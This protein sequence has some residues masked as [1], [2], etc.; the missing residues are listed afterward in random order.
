MGQNEETRLS[1]AHQAT[2]NA[3]CYLRLTVAV[4]ERVEHVIR[5]ANVKSGKV[6]GDIAVRFASPGQVLGLELS[7][8]DSNEV[9]RDGIS[10]AVEKGACPLW[11][12]AP[13]PNA[14][15]SIL[16]HLALSE[17][18][19][20]IDGFLDV[21]CSPASIQPCDWMGICV[22]DGLGDWAEL[23]LDRAAAA[24]NGQLDCYFDPA[25]G[26]RENVRGNPC[27]GEPGGPESTGPFARLAIQC[28]RAGH[29]ALALAE[30]G[31]EKYL[32]PQLNVVGRS[33]VAETS[34]N[35][36]YPMMALAVHS[37]KDEYFSRAL[38][39]LE[40]NR[41]YLSGTDVLWL[42]YY[43]NERGH[44][45]RSWS[46]GVAWYFLGLIRT[47]SLLNP[48]DRPAGLV[49]EACRM[50]R[51]VSRRQLESGLWPCFFDEPATL[52]DTSG[53]AGI[54]AAV[55]IGVRQGI[56]PVDGLPTAR[57]TYVAL[58]DGY[59]DPDGW[60]RGVA[61]SNKGEAAAVDLQRTN[62]R[63]IAPWGMGL[64][65]QLAAALKD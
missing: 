22:L 12:V 47:L 63:I 18:E 39:Q 52:P 8:S 25:K 1:W 58:L 30:M 65:A 10:L 60:L 3:A 24:L 7:Y 19:A 49:A 45:F 28:G 32:H 11:L 36:A 44:F 20:T 64:F 15:G 4:D 29:P 59:L 40:I 57:R 16:P 41:Q 62:C 17:G 13:G 14:P 55:A 23:G 37:G 54:A 33:I 48:G 46:R 43:G 5:V 34:Y 26:R 53:C 42:R 35:I 51:W 61:P 38:R 9:L 56:L 50:A 21:F 31:F 27:D 2:V 6:Y